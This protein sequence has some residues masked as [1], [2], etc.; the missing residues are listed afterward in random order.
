MCS[1]HIYMGCDFIIFL[2]LT[3]IEAFGKL[4]ENSFDVVVRRE[5]RLYRVFKKLCMWTEGGQ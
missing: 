5:I 3:V 2:I 1:F 4:G